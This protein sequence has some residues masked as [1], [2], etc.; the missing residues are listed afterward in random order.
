MRTREQAGYRLPI[1]RYWR[2]GAIARSNDLRQVGSAH[3]ACG[4]CSPPRARLAQVLGGVA[5]GRYC[6]SSVQRQLEQESTHAD[7]GRVAPS[8]GEADATAGETALS[9]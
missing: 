8:P 7:G 6:N 4:A 5:F 3:F 2:F 9:L 1:Q